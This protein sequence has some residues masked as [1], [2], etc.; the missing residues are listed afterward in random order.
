[1]GAQSTGRSGGD[2]LDQTQRLGSR[3]GWSANHHV[4][5]PNSFHTTGREVL[6]PRAV[7]SL[8]RFRIPTRVAAAISDPGFRVFGRVLHFSLDDPHFTPVARSRFVN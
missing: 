1:M 6:P 2:L 7:S 8:E 3:T 4:S 5:E